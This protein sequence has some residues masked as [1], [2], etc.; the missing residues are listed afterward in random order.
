[1]RSGPR[2]WSTWCRA[3]GVGNLVHLTLPDTHALAWLVPNLLLGG[4]ALSLLIR[5]PTPGTLRFALSF[6]GIAVG[7][8]W[9]LLFLGDQLTQSVALTLSALAALVLV[10]PTRNSDAALAAALRWITLGVYAIAA[11]H[12][13]NA[14]FLDPEV[15]CATGGVE[16][17][18]ANWSLPLSDQ[19]LSAFWPALFLA[20]EAGLV[21]LAIARPALALLGA[22]LMH[23][24]LTIV[25]APAFA[26]VML[27]GWVAFLRDEDVAWI[28]TVW[29]TRRRLVLTLGLA[30]AIASAAL[31]FRDHW[32]PYPAWQL[33][34][35][36][37]W[38][39]LGLYAVALVTRAPERGDALRGR[40]AWTDRDE[41]LRWR[42]RLA[43][44]FACVIA[45]NAAT[46][47]LGVQFHHAGAMLSNLRVDEGCWNHLLV[48]ERV[49]LYDPYVRVSRFDAGGAIRGPAALSEHVRERL[50]HPASFRAAL[51]RYCAAGA[52]P[53]ALELTYRGAQHATRDACAAPPP[54]PSQAE[55]LFQTN[56]LREC[57]QRCIH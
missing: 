54:L 24:P 17:L 39:L 10:P 33:V 36:S 18:A 31:Y 29:R 43:P 9:P 46:P 6:G 27:P 49:R 2:R 32:I 42:H 26:W 48:P 56:L 52:A 44:L 45:A 30:P 23:I 22:L 40:L 55:G 21:A 35:L 11:F 47:Y 34:E 1:M 5:P 20:T 4:G 13:L 57:P 8:L 19:H 25:F 28:A 7:A 14:D 38:L 12:K 3:F 16:L 51:T 41:G 53:L 15:S 50:W 37:L